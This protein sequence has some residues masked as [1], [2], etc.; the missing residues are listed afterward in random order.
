MKNYEV[1]KEKLNKFYETLSLGTFP[2]ISK[3]RVTVLKQGL[4][5]RL[6]AN[7]HGITMRNHLDKPMCYLIGYYYVPEDYLI[8]PDMELNKNHE[9]IIKN[10]VNKGFKLINKPPS[11]TFYEFTDNTKEWEIAEHFYNNYN[12]IKNGKFNHEPAFAV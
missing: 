5:K 10:Y 9:S 3:N 2:F 12:K 6:N 1:E 8:V 11:L 7:Y 4:Y